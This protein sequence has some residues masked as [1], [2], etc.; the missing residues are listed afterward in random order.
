MPKQ[1]ERTREIYIAPDIVGKYD[2]GIP[3]AIDE[4]NDNE[5]LDPENIVTKIR[6]YEREVTEWFLTPATNLLNQNGSNNSFVVLMICMSYIEGVEQYKT[7]VGSNRRSKECFIDSL[8]RLYPNKYSTIEIG[9]LYSKSRCGLF[10][11]GMVKG[12]VVFNN[13][14]EDVF[15]FINKGEIININPS[16]LLDRII[17]DFQDYISELKLSIEDGADKNLCVARENFYRMFS[18]L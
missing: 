3:V 14:Y 13:D 9:N 10:H 2:N 7:G 6:I 4:R 17:N 18:V 11:N 5:R 16:K 1:I 8:N 12:G 15:E